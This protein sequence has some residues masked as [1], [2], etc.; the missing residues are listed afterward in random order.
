MLGLRP[1]AEER[2]NRTACE[3]QFS[4]VQFNSVGFNIRSPLKKEEL[5]EMG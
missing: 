1:G 5:E 4:S 3:V 2:G